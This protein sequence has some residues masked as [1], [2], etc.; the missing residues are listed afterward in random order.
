MK[1]LQKLC[2]LI[3]S[4][5]LAGALFSCEA[6]LSTGNDSGTGSDTGFSFSD[7]YSKIDK[8]QQLIDSI[9]IMLDKLSET[10]STS[11]ILNY[12]HILNDSNAIAITSGSGRVS[13][14]GGDSVVLVGKKMELPSFDFTTQASTTYHIRYTAA[15]GWSLN[16]LSGSGYNP[17]TLSETDTAF[18]SSYEDMLAARVVTDA[19][20]SVTVT[21]LRNK[22]RLQFT[23]NSEV[24][25]TA[26][27]PADSQPHTYTAGRTLFGDVESGV[28]KL[29]L[30]SN[31][32]FSSSEN[33]TLNW[34]R[35]PKA[36]SLNNN[37]GHFGNAP[38]NRLHGEFISKNNRYCIITNANWLLSS[39][40]GCLDLTIIVSG[41][42]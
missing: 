36:V 1:R 13:Y 40:S 31:N 21:A 12:P 38:Q 33:I 25:C 39:L 8:M 30:R 26:F 29:V 20:N 19:G 35:Q 5:A 32:Y 2:V 15:K 4:L 23:L 3:A 22:D 24:G 11:Y 17:S 18:D 10:Q 9:N 14:G 27:P 7:L 42:N 37:Q 34:A 16:D 28:R 6:G 41:T